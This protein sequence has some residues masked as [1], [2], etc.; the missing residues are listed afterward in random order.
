MLIHGK[1][2]KLGVIN[3]IHQNPLKDA[4]CPDGWNYCTPWDRPSLRAY[5][6]FAANALCR[7]QA[8]QAWQRRRISFRD[9]ESI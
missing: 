4:I 7:M 1:M 9:F 5:E 6:H 2:Q 3:R 8:L